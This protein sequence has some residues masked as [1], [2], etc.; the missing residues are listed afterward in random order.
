MITSLFKSLKAK[1]NFEIDQL[2]AVSELEAARKAFGD[3]DMSAIMNP[4]AENKAALDKALQA[5][6]D[7]ELAVVRTTARLESFERQKKIQLEAEAAVK[8]KSD[9]S[10]TVQLANEIL[11][12]AKD[13]EVHLG[14]AAEKSK[15]MFTKVHAALGTVPQTDGTRGFD[16]LLSDGALA[17]YMKLEL[18]RCGIKMA[19]PWYQNEMDIPSF[20][21]SLEEAVGWLVKCG[22]EEVRSAGPWKRY[23]ERPVG[24]SA[25]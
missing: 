24:K 13:I 25:R 14:E 3:A 7:A 18:R 10:K 22:P 2:T 5:Y 19:H 9:W 16:S 23:F 20:Q 1:E 6:K 4:S 8:K 17:N 12:L 11:A 15:K 21:K